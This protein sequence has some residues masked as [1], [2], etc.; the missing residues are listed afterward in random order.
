MITKDD[1]LNQ[2]MFYH[3]TRRNSDGS[4]LRCRA[5]GRCRTWKRKPEAF[6][7][8]VKYGLK[9]CF[10]LD[11]NNAHEWYTEDITEF[12]R[13]T[14]YRERDSQG[15]PVSFFVR[16]TNYE[17]YYYLGGYPPRLR[18][19]R[20]ELAKRLGLQEDTPQGILEDA[21]DDYLAEHNGKMP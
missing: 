10:Y 19:V 8:P 5:N 9:T 14:Y 13:F 21:L 17:S 20:K 18:Y 2:H 7:L 1:A 4:A 6:R 11:N 15:G 12:I 16:H 3:A